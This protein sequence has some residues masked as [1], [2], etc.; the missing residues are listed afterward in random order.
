MADERPSY[1]AWLYACRLSRAID[2][3]RYGRTVHMVEHDLRRVADELGFD[4]VKRGKQEPLPPLKA[5]LE[6]DH[7]H[8]DGHLDYS[9]RGE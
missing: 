5:A 8:R 6:F 3:A 2:R 1:E 4:V 7:E 9:E